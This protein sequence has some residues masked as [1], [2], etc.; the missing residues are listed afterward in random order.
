MYTVFN[1]S[2]CVSNNLFFYVL[3]ILHSVSENVFFAPI[4]WNFFSILPLFA[5]AW[6]KIQI[7]FQQFHNRGPEL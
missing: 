2:V 7:V 4:I 6:K 1:F 5:I 3:F